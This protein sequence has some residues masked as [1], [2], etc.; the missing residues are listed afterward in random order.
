MVTPEDALL[1]PVS[2]T[3][4]AAAAPPALEKA[5][6]A[7][8]AAG[9][10]SVLEKILHQSQLLDVDTLHAL[11]QLGP[12]GNAQCVHCTVFFPSTERGQTYPKISK[13]YT[14]QHKFVPACLVEGN[15]E[16][17]RLLM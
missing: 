9:G 1:C 2:V 6:A 10:N 7:P 13:F 11:W 12:C 17:I 5:S 3:L 15:I 16:K 8:T 14:I 4:A